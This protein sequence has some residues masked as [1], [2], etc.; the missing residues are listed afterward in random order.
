MSGLAA[1]GTMSGVMWAAQRAGLLGEMPPKKIVRRAASRAPMTASEPLMKLAG[2]A[3][4][5]TYGAVL[6]GVFAALTHRPSAAR[7]TLYGAIVW[8]LNYVGLLPALGI[9][10][11]PNRDKR[12]RPS[13]MIAAHLVYG[14]VLDRTLRALRAGKRSAGW[15]EDDTESIAHSGGPGEGDS[16]ATRLRTPLR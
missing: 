11:M 1:T 13:S 15:I 14:W 2:T 4:H 8:A 16:S 3:A 9:M 10:R 5:F 12:G 6:G 7:G